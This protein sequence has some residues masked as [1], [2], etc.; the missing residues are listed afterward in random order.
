MHEHGI[1]AKSGNLFIFLK[2]D[3]VPPLKQQEEKCIK[4]AR[5]LYSSGLNTC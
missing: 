4:K 3:D 2:R 1:Q 5:K